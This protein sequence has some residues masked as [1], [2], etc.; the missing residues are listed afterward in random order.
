M[1][2]LRDNWPYLIEASGAALLGSLF[3]LACAVVL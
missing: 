3:G 1:N 2:W